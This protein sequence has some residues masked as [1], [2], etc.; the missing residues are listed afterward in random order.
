MAQILDVSENL[1]YHEAVTFTIPAGV[2]L[3]VGDQWAEYRSSVYRAL[4]IQEMLAIVTIAPNAD[5]DGPFRTAARDGVAD[6]NDIAQVLDNSSVELQ[7][8][9]KII[10]ERPLNIVVATIKNRD[11]ETE[12]RLR[13]L[14]RMMNVLVEQD[15]PAGEALRR[16]GGAKIDYQSPTRLT[17]PAL[18]EER[19]TGYL[20][21]LRAQARLTLRSDVIVRVSVLG[22]KKSAVS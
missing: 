18:I 3:N 14:E 1:D 20:I 22:I 19:S 16:L 15:S 10:F 4:I 6:A 17:I 5:G 7:A 11:K 8:H 21:R 2:V 12:E 13:R 9:D